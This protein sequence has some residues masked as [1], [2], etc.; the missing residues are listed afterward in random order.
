MSVSVCSI[1]SS[2][3]LPQATEL[4]FVSEVPRHPKYAVPHQCSESS[5]TETT[6]LGRALMYSP[7]FSFPPKG[8]GTSWAFPLNCGQCH[9][10]GKD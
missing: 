4:F 8:E 3:V 5:V 1:T 6:P 10:E 7:L 2:L 9:V